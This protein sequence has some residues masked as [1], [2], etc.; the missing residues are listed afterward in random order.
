MTD[1]GSI[2]V[3]I[4]E[5]QEIIRIGLEAI[6]SRHPT[7]QVIGTA[8]NG[9]DAYQRCLQLN[10]DVTIMD[11]SMPVMNGVE[12]TRLL[13]EKSPDL[14]V[15]IVTSHEND[16]DIFASFKAGAD[17]YCLKTALKGDVINAI[18][19]VAEG[20]AWLDARIADRVLQ[21]FRSPSKKPNERPSMPPETF[22]L[23]ARE[24]EVLQLIV[25][26]CT[27]AAIAQRLHVATQ[28]I[29]THIRHIM[30]KLAVSDRTQAAV[31]ALRQGIV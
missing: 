18:Q 6:I 8:S 14:K 10:P 20:G 23:T 16:D 29:K 2:R 11:L 19:T 4:A 7:M 12:A 13:R 22:N 15:L 31:K 3:F 24:I 26:G 21:C 1:R 5:D 30:E 27:N 9:Q 17:G 25:E 28:T